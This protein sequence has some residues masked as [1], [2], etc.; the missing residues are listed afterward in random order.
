MNFVDDARDLLFADPTDTPTE[1]F[2]TMTLD[3]QI[4]Y[5]EWQVSV[6]Q[7]HLAD[8]KR[9][10]AELDAHIEAQYQEHLERENGRL[11]LEA[12][13]HDCKNAEVWNA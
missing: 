12:D 3:E 9:K 1:S 11:T 13:A 4:D 7:S 10:K 2:D 6:A 8:L 5:A